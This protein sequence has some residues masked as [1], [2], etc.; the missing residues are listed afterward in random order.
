MKHLGQIL[1]VY[2]E[3]LSVKPVTTNYNGERIDTYQMSLPELNE[4]NNGGVSVTFL[5]AKQSGERK[6]KFDSLLLER[7]YQH[8]SQFLESRGLPVIPLHKL[9]QWHPE[10]KLDNVP[11]IPNSLEKNDDSSKRLDQIIKIRPEKVELPVVVSNGK[12]IKKM[13][14]LEKVR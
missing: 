4:E 13:T 1:Q 12:D 2:P 9:A 5:L 8:H 3:A 14:V 10:F 11:E 6:K 7:V